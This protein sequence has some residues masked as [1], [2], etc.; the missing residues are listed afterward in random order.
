LNCP[1]RGQ[2]KEETTEALPLAVS[3]PPLLRERASRKSQGSRFP[4]PYEI[5]NMEIRKKYCLPENSRID[6]MTYGKLH[7]AGM[8]MRRFW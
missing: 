3:Y 8:F 5:R 1:Q 7:A 4:V 2:F 6:F